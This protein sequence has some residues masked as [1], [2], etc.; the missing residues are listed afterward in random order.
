MDH[1][2]LTPEN[3]PAPGGAYVIVL[4]Y[5][6]TDILRVRGKVPTSH[7]NVRNR[8][9]ARTEEATNAP[10]LESRSR[11]DASSRSEL[12]ATDQIRRVGRSFRYNARTIGPDAGT[13]R[14]ISG[15]RQALSPYLPLAAG[16]R[17]HER[18]L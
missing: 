14:G 17:R 5:L 3:P 4:Q 8:T 18:R 12:I 10:C 9:D 7:I 11:F 16:L 6:V 15:A 13:S 2:S 1:P